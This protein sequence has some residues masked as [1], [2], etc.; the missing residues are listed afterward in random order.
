MSRIALETKSGTDVRSSDG[1]IVEGTLLSAGPSRNGTWYPVSTLQEAVP[2]LRGVP[3]YLDH[4]AGSRSVRDVAGVV[5]AAWLDQDRIRGR[6]RLT[7][8]QPALATLLKEG[9]AGGLS[10]AGTGVTRLASLDGAMWRVVESLTEIQSVDFVTVPA[11]GGQV[12]RL[13]ESVSISPE[14]IDLVALGARRRETR[15]WLLQQHL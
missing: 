14:K 2:R 11:A 5:E 3:C 1:L 13:L 12:E 7:A 15:A 8:S 10:I 9:L 4:Q 6:I